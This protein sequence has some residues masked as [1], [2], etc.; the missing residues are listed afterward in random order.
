MNTI[1]SII[2]LNAIAKSGDSIQ[3]VKD[4]K[5]AYAIA[6]SNAAMYFVEPPYE[7]FY[8]CIADRN[9]TKAERKSYEH[10]MRRH[11]YEAMCDQQFINS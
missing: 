4:V 9:F 5:Q 10:H 2:E 3:D 7:A 11:N 8:G 1:L 6:N